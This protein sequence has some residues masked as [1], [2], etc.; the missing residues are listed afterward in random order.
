MVMCCLV[1]C[2]GDEQPED[3]APPVEQVPVEPVYDPN[4][5]K[6][7]VVNAINDFV[8]GQ[9]SLKSF[10]NQRAV[11]S[12]VRVT[13][14]L[15]KNNSDSIDPHINQ[16]AW[17]DNVAYITYKQG[18]QKNGFIT[19][20]EYF[21]MQDEGYYLIRTD[22]SDY[23]YDFKP[24]TLPDV[25]AAKIHPITDAQVIWADSSKVFR[26]SPDYLKD[27]AKKLLVNTDFLN[28]FSNRSYTTEQ[29]EQLI[30]DC[31]MTA[32]VRID[33]NTGKVT[34]V[35]FTSALVQNGINKNILNILMKISDEKIEFDLKYTLANQIHITG[36]ITKNSDTTY[37]VDFRNT[38]YNIVGSK[39]KDVRFN[40]QIQIMNEDPIVLQNNIEE[41]M[42]KCDRIISQYYSVA[43]EFI[44]GF[45]KP[46]G[47][48][49]SVYVYSDRHRVYARLIPN[50]TGDK[51]VL[52][53]LILNCN[54]EEV[55]LAT[56]QNKN[57]YI[58]HHS[59]EEQWLASIATKYSS[60]YKG[61]TSTDKTCLNIAIYDNVYER[62]IIFVKTNKGYKYLTN[63]K[64]LGDY[65][66]YVCT[67]NID[68]TTNTIEEKR[69]SDFEEFYQQITTGTV[70]VTNI[71]SDCKYV[72]ISR[73]GQNFVFAVEN[74]IAKFIGI[75]T[76]V[77]G[78]C[79]G[80]YNASKSMISM[81]THAA[82]HK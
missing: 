16:I 25:K 69:H 64:E 32:Y 76:C 37:Y 19:N 7:K 55:C 30:K 66:S 21:V 58:Q 65:G 68:L 12:N 2:G 74:G 43:N 23:R 5:D 49:E 52:D 31:N 78:F 10:F 70:V 17:S 57:L 63:V 45:D 15:D 20:S 34:E 75:S 14:I 44:R 61:T 47:S 59:T 9:I 28:N 81:S 56:I 54:E 29:V 38:Q 4:G 62:F 42:L 18:Y 51:L 22:G 39:D 40:F 71:K 3:T 82:D 72:Y 73:Y 6:L 60:Y 8:Q 13:D 77:D 46:Y 80:S 26:I 36:T 41:M 35:N 53:S 27:F 33:E 67:G 48:C 79:K 1:A 50:E 11:I 24:I